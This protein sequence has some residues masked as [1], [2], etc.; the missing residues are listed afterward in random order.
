MVHGSTCFHKASNK[1]LLGVRVSVM[2][3]KPLIY[4]RMDVISH[5]VTKYAFMF[6]MTKYLQYLS[7]EH[8]KHEFIPF[9]L[10]CSS[11]DC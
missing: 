10:L 5:R 3:P 6:L 8:L 1:N 9:L 7:N 11:H 2:K 4:C